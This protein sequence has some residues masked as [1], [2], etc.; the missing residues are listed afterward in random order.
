MK[1]KDKQTNEVLTLNV[2]VK[3]A[4]SLSL[5]NK[6]VELAVDETDYT[7]VEILSGSDW[8]S[9]TSDH[10]EIATAEKYSDISWV[11][12]NGVGH[13]GTFVSITGHKAGSTIIRI[14]DMSSE[15]V[16]QILVTVEGTAHTPAGLHAVDLGLPSGTK[17]ANMNVG[18]ESPEDYG[19]YYAWGET[20]EKDVYN[21]STYIH[22][23]GSQETCHNLG[24]DIAGTEYDVA[25]VKWGGDW[26]MPTR[27]QQ[28]ELTDNCSYEW[29][30][31]NGVY[32]GK[33]TGPNGNSIFLPRAGFRW[34]DRLHSEDYYGNYWSSTQD[35]NNAKGACSLYFRSGYADW[36]DYESRCCGLSVRPVSK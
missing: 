29:T 26:Q 14:K 4:P 20:E 32:G 16:A 19:G 13:Y 6:T 22:R 11:D 23:D 8:Y 31:V 18:A 36:D 10:P 24:E 30:N 3:R 12:E 34:N 9:I 27:E 33:F 1:V 7:S 21:W 2:E 25:H 15:E 5:S 28:A 17:W 35:P